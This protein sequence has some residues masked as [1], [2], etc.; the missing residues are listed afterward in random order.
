MYL[1]DVG[2]IPSNLGGG[3]GISVPV[4]LDERDLPIG[5]QVLAPPLGEAVLL[6]AARAV[7]ALAGFT[8]RPALAT[9]EV[10]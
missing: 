2:T 6:R 8:A 3:P 9:S 5:F 7:E 1:A 10:R 4:G